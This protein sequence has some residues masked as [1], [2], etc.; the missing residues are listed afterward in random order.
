MNLFIINLLIRE[1]NLQG[2]LIFTIINQKNFQNS[3]FPVDTKLP[4]KLKYILNL[5]I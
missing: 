2:K 5:I 3:S 4:Y 1:N